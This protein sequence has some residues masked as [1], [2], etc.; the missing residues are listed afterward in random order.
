ME[1]AILSRK[2]LMELRPF[3]VERV[4][5]RLPDGRERDYDL[6]QH[7]D[8]VTILPVD[9][10]GQ[11]HLVRQYRIGAQKELLEL[12]AGVMDRGELVEVAPPA[13][14]FDAPRHE[15]TRRLVAA[16]PTRRAASSGSAIGSAIGSAP[17]EPAAPPVLT[18][19]TAYGGPST[20]HPWP[21]PR[22]A[23]KRTDDLDRPANRPCA[24][25]HLGYLPAS[26]AEQPVTHL[27]HVVAP[28]SDTYSRQS[29]IALVAITLLYQAALVL[30]MR[31]CVS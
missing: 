31:A 27:R 26:P 29:S 1:P 18:S 19:A 10:L 8:A 20:G 3:D 5:F 23:R 15:V 7:V 9:N 2:T 17:V 25:A 16:L 28:L 21:R 30:G 11:V 4:H 6:V 14:L 24:E 22:P 13:E 12:P